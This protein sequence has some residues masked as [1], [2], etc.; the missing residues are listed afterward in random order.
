MP[1]HLTPDPAERSA[2]RV[3]ASEIS[4]QVLVASLSQLLFQNNLQTDIQRSLATGLLTLV[5]VTPPQ[6][7]A[8]RLGVKSPSAP[9]SAKAA[10]L[11]KTP[12]PA[13]CFKPLI[14][15][16]DQNFL[17]S[18]DY[19]LLPV[20]E[21]PAGGPDQSASVKPE[22]EDK[23]AAS[24]LIEEARSSLRTADART[25]QNINSLVTQDLILL[26][27]FVPL[28][29]IITVLAKAKTFLAA[30]EHDQELLSLSQIEA[31]LTMLGKN[32]RLMK[33]SDFELDSNAIY[34]LSNLVFEMQSVLSRRAPAPL[35]SS[36]SSAQGATAAVD[37]DLLLV[38]LLCGLFDTETINQYNTPPTP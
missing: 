15:L 3:A 38:T 34:P 35:G 14:N 12:A 17:G 6:F 18:A 30:E 10:P 23:R 2:L 9:T 5:G 7:S 8:A 33:L 4:C 11:N 20:V 29:E 1:E 24:L 19:Q 26:T 16:P 22:P 31:I 27:D 37:Q 21:S 36:A 13:R 28:A 32:Q 25:S